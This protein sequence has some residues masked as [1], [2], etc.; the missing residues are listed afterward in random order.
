MDIRIPIERVMGGVLIGMVAMM[1]IT[2]GISGIDTSQDSFESYFIAFSEKS[3]LENN[4]NALFRIATGL[5]LVAAAGVLYSATKDRTPTLAAIVAFGLIAGAGL[6]LVATSLQIVLVSLSDEYVTAPVTQRNSLL[7]EAR[8][9]AVL[10]ETTTGVAFTTMLVSVYTLAILTA[11]ENLV[12]R[13]LIGLPILSAGIVGVSTFMSTAGYWDD[14]MW[15]V[16]VGGG[17]LG[18]VWLMIAG[19]WLVFTPKQDVVA[20]GVL[21]AGT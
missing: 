6:E 14:G 7:S 19:F 21:P 9:I 18:V 5:S 2:A 8:T 1:L 15:F 10:V 17:L 3:A 16:L 12:P 11:R 13:W 4:L 20:P